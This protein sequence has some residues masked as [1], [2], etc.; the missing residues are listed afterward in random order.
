[1]TIKTLD[2]R[3]RLTLGPEWAGALAIIE[4]VKPG[5]LQVIRAEAVPVREAWLRKKPKAFAS[6]QRG[7]K[8]AMAGDFV[9]GPDLDADAALIERMGGE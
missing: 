8:Q 1:M 7:L 9:E 4:E 5:V 6:V 2:A 3:G